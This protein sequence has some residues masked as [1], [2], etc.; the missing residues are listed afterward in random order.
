MRAK[1][2]LEKFTR[3]WNADE[4]KRDKS[5]AVTRALSETKEEIRES[6]EKMM[7]R[8]GKISDALVNAEQMSATSGS[9]VNSSK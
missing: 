9:L 8:D 3:D 4:S 6:L 2:D 1:Q 7:E 5:V